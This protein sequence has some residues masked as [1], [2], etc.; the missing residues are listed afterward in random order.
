LSNRF[1]QQLSVALVHARTTLRS[2]LSNSSALVYQQFCLLM[3]T[4]QHGG[5]GRSRI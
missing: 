1:V 4:M 3:N 2:H 5:Q